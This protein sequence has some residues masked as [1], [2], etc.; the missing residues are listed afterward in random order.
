MNDSIL[1][2]TIIVIVEN[3]TITVVAGIIIYKYS[4]KIINILDNLK[5]IENICSPISENL[6]KINNDLYC[7][8]KKHP[9]KQD[10]TVILYDD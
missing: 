8:Q 4:K 1:F 5:H 10:D 3:I 9:K 6:K 2:W 7:I